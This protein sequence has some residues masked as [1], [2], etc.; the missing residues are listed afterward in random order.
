MLRVQTRSVHLSYLCSLWSRVLTRGPHTSVC[1]GICELCV[2]ILCI[3]C[4][5]L[6]FIRERVHPVQ[7]HGGQPDGVDHIEHRYDP[8]PTARLDAHV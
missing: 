3:D 2:R 7:H 1:R 4:F 6:A 8:R 5:S